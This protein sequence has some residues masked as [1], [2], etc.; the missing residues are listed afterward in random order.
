MRDGKPTKVPY[1]AHR[2]ACKAAVNA[3][4]TWAPF[5]AAVAAF[6]DGKADG[7]GVVL[8]D[9]LVGVDLDACRDEQ[10]G[11]ITPE[12]Q[13]IITDL[14]SYTEVSPSGTGVHILL[15]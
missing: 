12:A 8:G 15:H 6:E 9:G 7:V 1:Q 13:T 4:E 11:V 14:D 3:P 10:T 5:A 2:P